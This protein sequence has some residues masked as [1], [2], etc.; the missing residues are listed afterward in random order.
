MTEFNIER[1]YN[2]VYC[3]KDVATFNRD[4]VEELLMSVNELY[5][6]F[7]EDKESF[8]D[9]YTSFLSGYMLVDC[10]PSVKE[11]LMEEYNKYQDDKYLENYFQ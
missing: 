1:N 10:D 7:F 11:A 4:E 9:G 6:Q 3:L 2:N 8:E 5:K